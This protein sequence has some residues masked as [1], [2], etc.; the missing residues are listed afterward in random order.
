MRSNLIFVAGL[1]SMALLAGCKSTPA[2]KP[3]DQLT[4]QEAHGHAIFAAHC[5]ACHYE[6][7]DQP[8]QGPALLGLFKKQ[9]LPSGAPANDDRVSATILHGRIMMPGQPDMDP[10]EL[11]DLLAYL[12]TL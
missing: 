1:F 9:Y 7:T 6:R 3:L 10:Q 4:P 12:H 2:A 5:S 8:L 11:S